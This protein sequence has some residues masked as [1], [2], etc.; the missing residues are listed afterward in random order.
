MQIINRAVAVIKPKQPFVD[1]AN[2]LPDAKWKTSLKDL[3]ED[4]TVILIPEYDSNEEA[5]EYIDTLA[6]GIFEDELFG[7][8]TNKSWWPKNRT[9]ETFW[10]WFDVELHSIVIDPVDGP[11]EKEEV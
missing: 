4:S 6:E 8:C 1:W 5:E 7:W 9:R 10:K 2:Q 3:E 11:I